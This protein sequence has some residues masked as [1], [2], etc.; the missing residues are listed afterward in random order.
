MHSMRDKQLKDLREK[1]GFC[2]ALLESLWTALEP[3]LM[4]GAI[5]MFFKLKQKFGLLA[6][7]SKR[8]RQ[9]VFWVPFWEFASS[10]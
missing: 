9:Q 1:E 3:H 4:S 7:V 2:I 5:H 8:A 10:P 6:N